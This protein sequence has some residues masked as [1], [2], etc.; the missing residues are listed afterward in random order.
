MVPFW[1]AKPFCHLWKGRAVGANRDFLASSD[2]ESSRSSG[3]AERKPRCS[4]KKGGWYLM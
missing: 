3:G 4:P 1:D 2:A